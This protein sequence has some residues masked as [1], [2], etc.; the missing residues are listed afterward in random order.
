MIPPSSDAPPP[1][2]PGARYRS[3]S[4]PESLQEFARNLREG[5]YISDS[6]GR[7]LDANP[8]MVRLM[9]MN[10]LDELREYSARTLIVDPARR[11]QELAIVERDGF[12]REFELEL[13]RPDGTRVTVLDTTYVVEDPHTGE[14]FYHGILVDISS[15]KQ[16][17][18]QLRE[19]CV[20]DP[21]TGA[22]NRRYLQDLARQMVE[23]GEQHWGCVYIDIDHFKEVNDRYGHDVGDDTLMRMARFLMRQ[24]RAE[25]A[26]VRLGGDEFLVV[27]CGATAEHTESV[28]RRL[29]LEAFRSAPVPFSLGW[30]AREGEETLEQTVNRADRHLLGARV[31][32][33][34][35]TQ[36]RRR[37]ES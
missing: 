25:E 22:Y 33:R 24:V 18:E 3:L 10:S 15:R 4:D 12:A 2:A 11:A 29:Q 5:I 1:P 37:N 23:R 34:E 16:L 30:A 14:R 28:A 31:A 26:V 8:A 13:L 9:G 17:E 7:L 6:A 20:R 32:R 27:L 19:M 36:H 35:S 21:L